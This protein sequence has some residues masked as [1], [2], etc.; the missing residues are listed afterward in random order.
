MRGT[1]SVPPEQLSKASGG[2]E[3]TQRLCYLAPAGVVHADEA[4]LGRRLIPTPLALAIRSWA[5]SLLS[6]LPQ[7]TTLPSTTRAGVLITP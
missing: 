1:V 6:A 7:D 4:T 3:L 2:Q 5:S